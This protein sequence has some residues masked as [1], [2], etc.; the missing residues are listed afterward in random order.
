VTALLIPSAFDLAGWACV[1]FVALAF[2]GLGRLVSAGRAAPEI[3]LVAG[4]GAAALVLTLWGVTTPLSLRVPGW[5][6][7]ALGLAGLIAPRSRL[8]WAEWRGIG[9]I[10]LLALPL[11]AVMASARPSQPD[12]FLNLLPNAAYLV[13]HGFFPADG[14]PDA[15][16]YLPAAPYNQQLAAF[17]AALAMPG[18]PA[19][20]LIGFNL[21]LQLA[22]GLLLARLVA[23]SEDDPGAVPSWG[24]TALGVLLAT[25]FNPG[26]VPRY[27]LSSYGEPSVAVALACAGFLAA[28]RARTAD[29]GLL[30]LV[31][32]ALVS[33]KPDS[34]ALALGVAATAA[35]LS[36]AHGE[37]RRLALSRC[38]LAV[39]PALVLYLAWHW[40]VP[41]HFASP[42]VELTTLPL[43]SWQFGNLPAILRSM[44]GAVA[45][46]LPFFAVLFAVIGVFFV[47]CRR[48]PVAWGAAPGMRAAAILSGV[49][50]IY[51]VALVLA[52]V[53]HFTGEMATDAHSYFR[54]NTHL[55]LLLMVAATWLAR[56]WAGARLDALSARWRRLLPAAMI[57][58]LLASPLVF[59]DFLRFDLEVPQQ[60]AWLLAQEI[61]LRVAGGD[62]LMLILPGD[63]GS[64]ATM[65][66][67]ALRMTPPRRNDLQIGSINDFT[68]GTLGLI[69]GQEN[70]WA[71][72]SCA[73][74]GVEGVPA[75]QAALFK[76]DQAGW[77]V[78]AL[79]AY[80]PAS[81][82]RWSRVV[83]EAPLCLGG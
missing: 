8:G 17:V 59:L 70:A 35:L 80:P 63:N 66:E 55:S 31:L 48:A 60:R 61:A 1:G 26:F 56:D 52:Y 33:I 10:L 28:R 14:R 74:A 44:L 7:A 65:I 81:R 75:G 67:G 3:A 39:L 42:D 21:V 2:M 41:S 78:A 69:A 76:R 45:E 54:Y 13:D 68:P 4:W 38:A 77:H 82:G 18:F 49:A 64:L 37:T 32:A 30:A 71:L 43:A 62:R 25:A 19:N 46:K 73:P 11:L 40:Y 72:L 57:V 22:A 23:K 51:T 53:A 16:S 20:A 27:D 6:L 24:A 36:P 83:S 5:I 58:I 79:L 34:V 47:R 15:Y 50:V 29:T 12:T 9:R